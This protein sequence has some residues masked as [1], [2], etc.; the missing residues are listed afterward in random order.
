MFLDPAQAKLYRSTRDMRNPCDEELTRICREHSLDTSWL[1]DLNIWYR[2]EVEVH[3]TS[4]WTDVRFE[5]FPYVLIPG[6]TGE[7]P[8]GLLRR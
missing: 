1:Q 7:T 3:T 2:L 6:G 8:S 4:D 5:G